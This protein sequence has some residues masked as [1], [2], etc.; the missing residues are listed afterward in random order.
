MTQQEYIEELKNRNFLIPRVLNFS[1][2]D[3]IAIAREAYNSGFEEGK[4]TQIIIDKGMR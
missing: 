3:I 4:N 1:E 2:E